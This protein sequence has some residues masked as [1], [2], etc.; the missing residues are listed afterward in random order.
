ML[1]HL[2][3][4]ELHPQMFY[5]SYSPVLLQ[6]IWPCFN[7]LNKLYRMVALHVKIWGSNVLKELFATPTNVYYDLLWCHPFLSTSVQLSEKLKKRKW[8]SS[9][10]EKVKKKSIHSQA[11][12]ACCW[13]TFMKLPFSLFF[14]FWN[15][16]NRT[17]YSTAAHGKP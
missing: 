3:S 10:L 4:D 15:Y 13:Y 11:N 5:F 12:T 7:W 1:C 2:T 14:P 8:K 16:K 9:L 6:K 17:S